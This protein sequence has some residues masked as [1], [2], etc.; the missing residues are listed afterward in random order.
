VSLDEG[1]LARIDELA[2]PGA[3]PAPRCSER[4]R[5]PRSEA[6]RNRAVPPRPWSANQPVTT[7]SLGPRSAPSVR[8]ALSNHR[9]KGIPR[10]SRR[11]AAAALL[12]VGAFGAAAAGAQAQDERQT[13]INTRA[14]F[15]PFERF[16]PLTASA[17]CTGV[18]GGRFVEP[19]RARRRLLPA[20]DRRG[21]PTSSARRRTRGPP[22]TCGT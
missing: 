7:R 5:R 13:A 1:T 14:D 6:A 21:K 16:D 20:G 19:F 9:A 12:T 2:P 3:R 8:R 18:P 11:R 17:P 22:R 15:T 4:P 10:M